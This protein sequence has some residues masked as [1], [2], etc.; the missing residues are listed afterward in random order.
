MI[1]GIFDGHHLVLSVRTIEPVALS[2]RHISLMIACVYYTTL[3]EKKVSI[4][5]ILLLSRILCCDT[6][7][8]LLLYYDVLCTCSSSDELFLFRLSVI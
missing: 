2:R 4:T 1:G 3:I 5:D 6:D 7:T 8:V